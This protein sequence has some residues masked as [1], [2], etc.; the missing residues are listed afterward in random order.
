MAGVGQN[1]AKTKGEKAWRNIRRIQCLDRNTFRTVFSSIM[2]YSD[3]TQLNICF[4]YLYGSAGKLLQQGGSGKARNNK[5][6]DKH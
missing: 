6:S 1:T 3:I 4:G 5:V 2:R